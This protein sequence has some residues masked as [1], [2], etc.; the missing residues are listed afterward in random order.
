[1]QANGRTA[2]VQQDS[3]AAW[4]AAKAVVLVGDVGAEQYQS[5]SDYL[6]SKKKGGGAHVFGEAPVGFGNLSPLV[7]VIEEQQQQETHDP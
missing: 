5:A 2:A 4:P 6:Q 3:N 1:M 7:G